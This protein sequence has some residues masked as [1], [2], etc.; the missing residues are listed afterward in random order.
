[1]YWRNPPGIDSFRLSSWFPIWRKTDGLTF[2]ASDH[3]SNKCDCPNSSEHKSS[4][5]FC[6]LSDKNKPNDASKSFGAFLLPAAALTFEDVPMIFEIKVRVV[7]VVVLL[8][9][10][11]LTIHQSIQWWSLLRNSNA[12]LLLLLE[13]DILCRVENPF[14]PH[15][16][17]SS[18]GPSWIGMA[19]DERSRKVWSRR[20]RAMTLG[21]NASQHLEHSH[22]SDANQPNIQYVSYMPIN[23]EI[24][25]NSIES[26]RWKKNG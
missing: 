24:K 2:S 23:R 5:N 1:M 3:P 10:E 6:W 21:W 20:E 4:I 19:I 22:N 18:S 25:S 8:W 7:V 16:C 14:F 12:G 26:S 9:S 15:Y 13:G 11:T 17:C